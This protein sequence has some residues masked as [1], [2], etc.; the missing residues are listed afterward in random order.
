MLPQVSFGRNSAVYH[1]VRYVQEVLKN[2]QMRRNDAKHFI[3]ID[4]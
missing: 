2:L 1:P 4:F 3:K